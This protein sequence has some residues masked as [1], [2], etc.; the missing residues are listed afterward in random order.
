MLAS[1]TLQ[2]WEGWRMENI[3]GGLVMLLSSPQEAS[4]LAE[5]LGEQRKTLLIG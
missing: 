3:W 4:N 2:R 5:A 1:D